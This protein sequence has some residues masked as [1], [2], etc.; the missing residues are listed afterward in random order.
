MEQFCNQ[1]IAAIHNFQQLYQAQRENNETVISRYLQSDLA[2]FG[3]GVTQNHL[4]AR[5]HEVVQQTKRFETIRFDLVRKINEVEE[6]KS[7]ELAESCVAGIL[8]FK[9]FFHTCSDRLQ[10]SKNFIEE[11]R[12]K[13][14]HDRN[15]YELSLLPLD[16]KKHDINAVLDAMVERVEMASVFLQ[17][18]LNSTTG[19]SDGTASDVQISP[20]ITNS[21]SSAE[22]AAASTSTLSRLGAFMGGFTSSNKGF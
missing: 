17:T 3:R 16:R 22:S 10:A 19:V 14:H 15:A 21:V 9:T 4:D 1:D 13:Q 7:F 12:T 18:D 20:I 8:S 2:N 6:R 5:A 11:L